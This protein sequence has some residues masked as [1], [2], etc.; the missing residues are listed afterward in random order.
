MTDQSYS[1]GFLFDLDGVIINSES[2]YSRIW[3][4]INEEYPTGI[5]KMEEKIKGCTL[6]KILNEYY[7]DN[8]TRDAVAKRLHELED[9]MVYDY[10]PFAE[11]FLQKLKEKNIRCALVTSS[12]N[13]KMDHLVKDIPDILSYFDFVVTG[14]MVTK[15]K[16]SPE[17]YLLGAEKICKDPK[18]CVVFEDSLQGVMAG[19]NA[20]ALVVGIAGTLPAETLRPYSDLIINDFSELNPEDLILKIFENDK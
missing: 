3:I 1:P 11:S 7:S 15:S 13:K 9:E 10:L 5:D 16:P 17:G 8:E 18:R 6:S 14:D 20:G 4:K 2:E 19:K 12:D